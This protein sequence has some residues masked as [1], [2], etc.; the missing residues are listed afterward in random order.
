MRSL[1]PVRGAWRVMAEEYLKRLTGH[2]P[3]TWEERPEVRAMPHAGASQDARVQKAEAERLTQGLPEGGAL[4]ALDSRGDEPDSE[5]FARLVE[6]WRRSE[7]PV[8]LLVGGHLGLDAALRERCRL[9]SLSRLTF[10]HQMVPAFLFE[11]LYRAQD[12]L[13]GGPYHR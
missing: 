7:V 5:E 4:W 6:A 1:G 9:L 12:I 10:S 2:L 3:L 8:C 13:S 11:Q